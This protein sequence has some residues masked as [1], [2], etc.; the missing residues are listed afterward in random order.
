MT[1][2]P[3]HQGE[4]FCYFCYFCAWYPSPH[5]IP[6][7]RQ[8]LQFQLF[9][10]QYGHGNQRMYIMPRWMSESPEVYLG[11]YQ[12]STKSTMAQLK[13]IAA[14]YNERD[15]SQFLILLFLVLFCP[16]ILN[17]VYS[18][19]IYKDGFKTLDSGRGAAFPVLGLKVH[20][21]HFFAVG[22]TLEESI[23]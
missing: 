10:T 6:H 12:L 14:E 2:I 21:E 18:P 16:W 15:Y 23:S 7:A 17:F 22:Q 20:I 13:T 11:L 1:Q 9:K 8:V 5:G 3:S 4:N 19:N